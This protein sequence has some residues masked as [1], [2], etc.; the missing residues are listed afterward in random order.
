MLQKGSLKQEIVKSTMNSKTVINNEPIKLNSREDGHPF[1]LKLTLWRPSELWYPGDPIENVLDVQEIYNTVTTVGKNDLAEQVLAA[2][3]AN[4]K[5][6]HMAIGTGTG[7]TTSL[8]TELDRNALTSK[9]RST[10]VVTFV[11]D[12]AAGD[13][14]GALTEAGVFCQAAAGDMWLYSSFAVINKGAA[15]ALNISWGLTI[16]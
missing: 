15:D 11:G 9:T 5:P 14:T 2:P 8:T 7:G 13:G 6:T 3:A 10:N 12:W 4:T 1:H 16:S